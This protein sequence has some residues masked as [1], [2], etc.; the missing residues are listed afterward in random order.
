L[1]TKVISALHVSVVEGHS[2]GQATYHRVK[3]LF[4]WKGLKAYVNDFIKQCCVCQQAKVER[5]HSLGLLQPL[6]IPQGAWQDLTM[7]FIEGL[8]KSEGYDSILVVV[9]RFSKY[10]HFFL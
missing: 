1:R 5:I 9:D 2:R 8:P 3:R 6:S 10:A 4:W 7:Y